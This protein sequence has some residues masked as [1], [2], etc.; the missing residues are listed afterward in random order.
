V[1][2]QMDVVRKVK[3]EGR[4]KAAVKTFNRLPSAM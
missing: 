1:S 2:F 3:E 4:I